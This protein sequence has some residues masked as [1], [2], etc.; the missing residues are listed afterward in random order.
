M[1]AVAVAHCDGLLT[2]DEMGLASARE[3]GDVIYLLAN[4]I[5]KSRM[6]ATG[7][8]RPLVNWRVVYLSS[9]EVALRDKLAEGGQ[10]SRAGQDIRLLNLSAD[11]GFGLGVFNALHGAESAA[12]L[13][14]QLRD[15]AAR[16]CGTAG[17]AF[18]E[19]LVHERADDPKGLASTLREARKKF[20]AQYVPK[21]ADGQV[22]GAAARLA[23]IGIAGELALHYRVVPWTAGQAL[24]AAGNCFRFWLKWRGGHGAA[25]DAQALATLKLFI[26]QHGSSR[27]EN[28]MRAAEEQRVV[29]RAGFVRGNGQE[30]QFL[31]LPPVWHEEIFKGMDPA[32]AA[33]AIS[34]AGFLIPGADTMSRVVKIRG[35][36]PTRVYVVRGSILG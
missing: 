25:E 12:A 7:A 30:Q 10:H 18:L 35:R 22:L 31:T 6:S 20:V 32:R 27:F 4:Q 33:D 13:A 28:P 15:D 21:G 8:A 16:Y 34:R 3:I 26:A 14:D 1:E 24:H 36:G 5:P 11:A 2:L 29:N 19:T 17:P 9:G 23:L